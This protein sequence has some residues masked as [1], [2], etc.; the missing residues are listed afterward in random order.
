MSTRN[1]LTCLIACFLLS[2][3]PCRADEK[4]VYQDP[5][6]A[7]RLKD[8]DSEARREIIRELFVQP[9]K[10][11]EMDDAFLDAF[12][13]CADDPDQ[14]V[15]HTAYALI[16]ERWIWKGGE[17]EPRAI[18]FL[19]D[20]TQKE[21]ET[22][23]YDCVYYGLSTLRPMSDE[24]IDRLIELAVAKDKSESRSVFDRVLWGFRGN[25]ERARSRIQT[26]LDGFDDS[27]FSAAIR[28]V[29]LYFELTG[30]MPSG[31]EKFADTGTY[32]IF[33]SPQPPF[34]PKSE[35]ELK[36]RILKI[37]KEAGG[38]D[39]TRTAFR[40]GRFFG[41]VTTTGM[42]SYGK[43]LQAMKEDGGFQVA[44]HGLAN[45][46]MEAFERRAFGQPSTTIAIEYD[47]AF[48]DLFEEI[49]EIY[50]AFQ[51]KGIDWQE[52]GEELL[53]ESRAIKTHD[54]F[55]LL[56]QRLIA[57][58]EDSH[59]HLGGG[60]AQPASP[61]FPRWD[62]GFACL[63]DDRGKLV[64]YYIDI[65][66][67]AE[68]AGLQ[69]GMTIDSINGVP[70]L[71]A[72]QTCS[73]QYKEYIGFSSDRLLRYQAS[74]WFTRQKDKNAAVKLVA[75]A[76]AG[77]RHEFSMMATL[78]VRYLPRLPV[79][80]EGISDSANVSWTELEDGIGYIYVRRIRNDL[81]DDLDRAV[82]QLQTAAGLII[83]VRGNS[84]G[85]FDANRS[86]RNF[87]L[88]DKAEPNRPRFTGPMAVLID[89]RCISAGEGWASWFIANQ[90]ATFFGETTAGAS[91]R[92][93]TLSVAD[94]LFQA[95]IPVKAYRGFIDRPIERRGLEP[96]VKVKQIAAD[97]DQGVDTVLESAREFLLK[98]PVAES[99]K[100]GKP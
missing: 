85:G 71:D 18:A 23:R 61:V 73:S 50:P 54:E 25:A 65:N 60:T 2:Y 41:V 26:Y 51:I 47:K 86:F 28:A 75:I 42:P 52:V 64:V 10:L 90:R 38:S 53:P 46:Q 55:S 78:D 44:A 88:N 49:G 79:P 67:P 27:D 31:V 13:A 62:P 6:V 87:D 57:R 22:I 45:P 70:A 80:I 100:P 33:F 84:G 3:L 35:N 95:T 59:A 81:I 30:N 17:Q 97:L 14:S 12:I 32:K 77:T 82:G 34:L 20:R 43:L 98:Q 58:L 4:P 9:K 63:T 69:V 21:N 39:N 89:S 48:S 83:D 66:S 92:K 19:L 94:G 93:R 68:R 5:Q 8:G 11:L 74:R 36:Q 40:A 7:Q 76:P 91:S 1:A 99:N 16:G 24:V 15:Q 56:C 72:L 37:A 29:S 96:D